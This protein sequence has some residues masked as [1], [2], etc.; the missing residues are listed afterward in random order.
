MFSNLKIG[1]VVPCFN[2][3]T[4]ISKVIETMPPFVDLIVVIDDKSTDNTVKAVTSLNNEK[5]KLL[6]FN[7]LKGAFYNKRLKNG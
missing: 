5:V 1:V 4:K 7:T 3:E 6:Y 2:E